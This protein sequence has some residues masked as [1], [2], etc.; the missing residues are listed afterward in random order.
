MT[1]HVSPSVVCDN[2]ESSEKVSQDKAKTKDSPE[3][4]KERKSLR[5]IYKNSEA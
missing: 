1:D 4:D 5:V 3:Q 2:S